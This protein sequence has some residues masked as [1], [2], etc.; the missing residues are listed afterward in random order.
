MTQLAH[1][2]AMEA[3]QIQDTWQ[4]ASFHGWCV[5]IAF[6]AL[7]IPSFTFLSGTPLRYLIYLLPVVSLGLWLLIVPVRRLSY[8][9]RFLSALLMYALIVLVSISMNPMEIDQDTWINALRPV[10][11]LLAFVPFL[12]FDDRSVKGV[13]GIYILT[14]LALWA[15]GLGTTRGGFSLSESQGLLESGLAFPLGGLV[16]YFVMRRKWSWSI[17]AFVLF[18]IAFKRVAFAALFAI[19]ALVWLNQ[20]MARFNAWNQQLAAM[21]MTVIILAGAV[22]INLFYY[23]FF[24]QLAAFFGIDQS[25]MT[26]TMGRLQEFEI[27]HRQYG[28]QPLLNLLFGNGPGDATRRMV[29]ITIDYPLQVH[30]SY[31]MYFYD[32][33]VIGF[34]LLLLSFWLIYSRS[35]F[36]MYLFMYN[37]IIMITDNSFTHHYHQITYFIL[38]GAMQV[39]LSRRSPERV[40]HA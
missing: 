31:L 3:R 26:L 36:G 19:I 38:M 37:L 29:E 5:L 27:L 32:F 11:Y 8:E 9:P 14:T 15:S 21:I 40:V 7:Y 6:G 35:L 24:E 23:E 20:F 18:F 30:N 25:V 4:R 16:L 34:G 33:G 13:V 17:I 28:D 22:L 10:F 12:L 2:P 1:S 39:E